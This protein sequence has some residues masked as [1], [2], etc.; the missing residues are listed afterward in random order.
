MLNEEETNEIGKNRWHHAPIH[1]TQS[2]GAYMI[3]GSTLHKEHLFSS[4]ES[5]DL[6]ESVLQEVV[7]NYR[8]GIRAW[9][10]FPNHYHL[11]LLTYEESRPLKSF[12]NH[13]HSLSSRKLNALTNT[14]GKQVWYQYWDT[15]LTYRNSYY[16]RL[17]YVMQNPVKHE[18]VKNAENY[19]WCS[20]RW[21]KENSTEGHYRTITSFKTDNI[22]V[23]DNF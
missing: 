1:R 14:R 3:T 10:L 18:L 2:T 7:E 4:S 19:R 16:A 15:Q 5:L 22:S 23:V 13:F 20:A 8:L 12:I 17:N 11:I 21:F 6:L 9:A